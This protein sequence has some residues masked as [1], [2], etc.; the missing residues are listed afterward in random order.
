MT[1]A[2]KQRLSP[3]P[4]E[5]STMT[6]APIREDSLTSRQRPPA[7]H[8]S[9][10]G[11]SAFADRRSAPLPSVLRCA[12]PPS[13]TFCAASVRQA[14][15]CRPPPFFPT[16]AFGSRKRHSLIA[17]LPNRVSAANEITESRGRQE[18]TDSQ[19]L[20]RST[21]KHNNDSVPA[22]ESHRFRTNAPCPCRLSPGAE[23]SAADATAW[24]QSSRFAQRRESSPRRGETDACSPCCFMPLGIPRK[25]SPARKTPPRSPP[26]SPP[27]AAAGRP[28]HAL[29]SPAALRQDAKERSTR[30]RCYSRRC[31]SVLSF[32]PRAGI[33]DRSQRAALTMPG[34]CR[35]KLPR[36]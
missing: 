31:C 28:A 8:D 2:T 32:R 9:L 5:L 16:D 30:P 1:P 15:A 29:R 26:R 10:A 13:P 19:H 4:V 6:S 12:C 21:S 27:L 24:P 7:R 14:S 25:N 18:L 33:C 11:Q 3:F 35:A 36:R 34:G 23:T 20:C 17:A 22:E